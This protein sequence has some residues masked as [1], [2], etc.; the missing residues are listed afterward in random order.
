MFTSLGVPPAKK[1]ALVGEAN[2]ASCILDCVKSPKSV[3]LPTEAI[4]TYWITFDIDGVLPP[5]VKPL[6]ELEA[7]PAKSTL[8]VRS[9]KSEAFP[10]VA[11]VTYSILLVLPA[12][13]PPANIPLIKEL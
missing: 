6:T 3:A 1:Q 9:P 10:L 7:P 4:V 13:V 5:A 2:P 11:I 12:G 8:V